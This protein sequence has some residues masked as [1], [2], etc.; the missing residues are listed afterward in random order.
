MTYTGLAVA[1]LRPGAEWVLRGDDID[2]IV[3][4][5]ANVVP[6][7]R[8]EVEAEIG[9]L[10]AEAVSKAA[11]EEAATTGAIAHAKSLGFTDAMISV[12]YPNLVTGLALT[13]DDYTTQPEPVIVAP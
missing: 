6:V 1:S 10:K 9:K 2:G 11:A 8:A 4:V 5:T 7:T 3:Y 12:M 13:A